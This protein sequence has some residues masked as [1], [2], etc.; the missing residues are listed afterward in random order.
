MNQQDK[1]PLFTAQAFAAN[2]S[3]LGS[4]QQ[5]P[6]A[7]M[8]RRDLA[9]R[10]ALMIVDSAHLKVEQGDHGTTFR[11][12]VMVMSKDALYGYAQK[13]ADQMNYGKGGYFSTDTK[14][15][16]SNG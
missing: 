3:F 16:R 12:E 14:E 5:G 6:L 13:L 8:M 4:P 15:G 7:E 11:L 9:Q 10:L 2:R 1:S